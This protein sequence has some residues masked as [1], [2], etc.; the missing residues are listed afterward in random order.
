[1]PEMP[2]MPGLPELRE[3]AAARSSSR[4][5]E[6]GAGGLMDVPRTGA[7]PRTRRAVLAAGAVGA[8]AAITLGLRWFGHRAPAVA[9]HELWIATVERGPLTLAVRGPG[10]LVPTEFRWAST[11]VAARVDRVR[12]QPGVA[13]EPDTLLVELANPDAELAA[14]TADRD[15]AQAEAQLAQLTAQLDGTRL[16]QESAVAGLGAD[17][18]MAKRR[19]TIDAAMA[20][21][22][23]IADL[24]SLESTDRAGQLSAR[25]VFEQKRL[26]ALRRG[27]AAQLTAQRAQLEQL[28]GLAE[29]RHRQLD[30]LHVRAGQAGVVQQIA[31]EAGQSVAAGAPLAK[32]VVPDHLQA[33]LKVPEASTQDLTLGL[34]ATIDTRTGIVTGEVIRIDP[35]AQNGSVTVDV[36][37]TAPLPKAARVDQNVEGV[38]DLARTGDVLHVA[39]PAIGEA[40][41]TASLFVLTAGGEARRVAVKFG[42]AAQ[43]EIEIASGLAAGDQVVL[44][45]MSRWDGTDRLRIQ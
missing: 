10:T 24:E 31:V 17:A 11:P 34:A 14:L 26:A 23:V 13:V 42:R 3:R 9:R 40:H 28:R 16:A 22:G 1:M 15:V 21:K 29:F 38:I 37:L 8:L 20:Q 19:S 5:A 44:S 33:R 35:A 43:K 25:L 39:R 12:V 27:N 6:P 4:S 7:R 30:A 36:K 18:V 32:I 45:D 2:E 41:Q